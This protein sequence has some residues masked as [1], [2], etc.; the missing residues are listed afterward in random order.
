MCRLPDGNTAYTTYT[1][2]GVGII[3]P[4]GRKI[5]STTIPGGTV[6]A[7]NVDGENLVV[8]DGANQQI[9]WLNHAL[10]KVRTLKMP[11]GFGDVNFV[12]R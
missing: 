3:S 10:Q 6:Y 11:N 2:G 8:G 5:S 7:I 1:D 4:D 12:R 9:V